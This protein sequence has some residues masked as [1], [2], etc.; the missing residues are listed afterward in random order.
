MKDSDSF[1][2]NCLDPGTPQCKVFFGVLGALVAVLI[3]F[4]GVWKTLFILL[5]CA[6]GI[7]FGTVKDKIA[8]LKRIINKLFPSR[9]K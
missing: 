6:I 3:L 1:F 8:M 4:I 5:F 9:G 7:F 2:S